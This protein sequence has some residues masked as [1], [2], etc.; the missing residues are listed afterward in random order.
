MP[1][2]RTTFEVNAPASRVWQV[3]TA[4]DCYDE[5]NPQIPKATGT[6]EE[7]ATIHLRLALPAL[8]MG[9]RSRG[10]TRH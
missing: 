4:L 2:Y 9:G 5:W 7:G 1:V 10:A 6:L 3:L 8:L